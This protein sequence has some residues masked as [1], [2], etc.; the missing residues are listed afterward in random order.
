[1]IYCIVFISS[2][3]TQIVNIEDRRDSARDSIGWSEYVDIRFSL[4]ENGQQIF[5]RENR[6]SAYLSYH[7][8]PNAMVS[9]SGTT[10]FQPSIRD[11][12]LSTQQNLS[13]KVI[14]I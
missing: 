6:L 5:S 2:L 10:Y 9:F 7:L 1:M 3:S 8:N 11:F 4:I 14:K 12:R 13:V